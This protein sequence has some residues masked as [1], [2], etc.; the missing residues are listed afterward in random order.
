MKR[1]QLLLYPFALVYNAVTAVRNL[2]F[3]LGIKKETSFDLPVIAVG[4]LAVGGTGKTPHVEYLLGFLM[5]NYRVAVLSRGYKRQTQG[6]VLA[7]ENASVQS[8]GD[9]PLQIKKKFPRATVSVCEKRVEG[10]NRLLKEDLKP[11]IILL[12]DAFQH[13][14]VKPG[15]R[16]LLSDYNR[17]YRKDFVM[18]AGR[19]REN[20]LGARRADIVI[21]TKCPDS[22]SEQT[23]SAMREKIERTAKADVFFTKIAYAGMKDVH[24]GKDAAV[25]SLKR[26]RILLLTG[27]ANPTP[28][29]EYVQNY[30][31]ETSLLSF[32]DHHHFTDKDIADIRD[33]YKEN[34]DCILTTEKDAM[35]LESDDFTNI[36]LYYLP[37]GIRVLEDKEEEFKAVVETFIKSFAS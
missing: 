25:E 4:N 6:Y 3:R 19:L 23:F 36:P 12:D 35:R 13:R 15:L 30:T 34:F 20:R 5:R 22:I 16:I 29:V 2:L 28:M 8:V 17:P 31:K 11:D 7:D 18:P 27:I 14:Y 37:I 10:I 1:L 33:R 26:K 32:P 21:M 9:E 24:T